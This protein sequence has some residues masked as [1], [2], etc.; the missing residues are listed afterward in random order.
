MKHWLTVLCFVLIASWAMGQSHT[1][2]RSG[3]VDTGPDPD[4]T[5][6]DVYQDGDAG[7]DQVGGDASGGLDALVI[8]N[9]SHAHTT[10]TISGL[11]DADMDNNALDADKIV[12][13]S[14]DDNDLDVAAGGTGVSTLT[15]GGILLGQGT[16]DIVALGVAANGE[17]PIGDGTTDPVL[18]TITATASETEVTNGAGSI[19]I[20]LPDDVTIVNLTVSTTLTLPASATPNWVL[21]D[22]NSASE[23]TDG[24]ISVDA[25]DTGAGTEDSDMT[26]RTQTNSTLT[27]RIVIDGDGQVQ[28]LGG[29]LEVNAASPADAGAVRLDNADSICWEASP[30]GTDVCITVDSSEFFQLS[31]GGLDAADLTTGTIPPARAGA[32]HIDTITEIA[33]AL[34]AGADG[35]LLTGTSGTAGHCSEWDANGDLVTSGAACGGTGHADTI[36]WTGTSVLETGTAHQIGD[37]TDA[38]VTHTYANT[39]TNVVIAFSS[40]LVNIST[41]ALQV[42]GSAVLEAGTDVTVAQGGTGASDAANARTNLGLVIGTDVQAFDAEL[43]TIA[44]LTETNDNVMFVA[45]GAWTS[46]ATPA[47]DCTDCTNVFTDIDTD[48]GNETVTSTWVFDDIADHEWSPV[49]KDLT[50][51]DAT[52]E[53]QIQMGTLTIGQA[54]DTVSGTTLDDIALF[55]NNAA[56]LAESISFVFFGPSDLPRFVLAAEGADLATYNPRSLTV[57]PAATIGNMDENVLCSTNFDEI[58]CDT[59][60]TGADLGVQDDIAVGG[61]IFGDAGDGDGFSMEL[62]FAAMAADRTLTFPDDEVASGDVLFGTGAG[63]F[64]YDATPAIDCVDCTNVLDGNTLSHCDVLYAPS[65]EVQATDDVQTVFRA[66]AALTI[67]EVFCETDTG[68]VTMDVQIDDG[69]PADVMG[70]DLVC[71]TSGETDSASLTGGMADGDRLDW[72]I[73]SVATSPTRVTVC[74]EYDFD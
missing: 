8:T 1:S 49:T 65:A 44:G 42:G 56:A 11:L 22:S 6:T 37:G 9:D 4:C 63:T 61:S 50:L 45:G 14:S 43:L 25:T 3:G 64:G 23:A 28:I 7:C 20:G 41:G 2:R 60:G 66:P 54:D 36:T 39:G 24:Q 31:G 47:I 58:D 5:G 70:T 73:T 35:T 67:T 59:G 18:G 12:G 15:D 74:I 57:G 16:G 34:K 32:D 27:D 40:A 19:T 55:Y 33:A 13:D 52:D 38:T 30:A 53:G 29:D 48:Y 71:D 51:G 17:I 68:T 62:A 10:T 72:A 26:F 69:S 21:D 46:D